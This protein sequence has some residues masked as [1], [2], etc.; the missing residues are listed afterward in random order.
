MTLLDLLKRI[1]N[2]LYNAIDVFTRDLSSTRQKLVWL[3]CAMFVYSIIY[4]LSNPSATSSTAITACAS[5][6]S[7]IVTG[8]IGSKMYECKGNNIQ[9]VNIES[10]KKDLT[11]PNSQS[12]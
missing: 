8:Y 2:N 5:V 6:F 7:L 3:G 4:G 12:D 10:R 11:D 9:N 1:K